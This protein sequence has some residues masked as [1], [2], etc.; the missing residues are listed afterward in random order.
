[1]GHE[2]RW[3]KEPL[4]DAA[5]PGWP[6]EQT[7]PRWRT[8]FPGGEDPVR[9]SPSSKTRAEPL[10]RS[11]VFSCSRAAG[12]A[13]MTSFCDLR[14]TGSYP[15]AESRGPGWPDA[16]I[17]PRVTRSGV[18]IRSREAELCEKC[19]VYKLT[20]LNDHCVLFFKSYKV[21]SFAKLRYILSLMLRLQEH[22][23]AILE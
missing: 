13:E 2:G 10:V 19:S 15:K 21:L 23:A 3:G 4:R 18:Y 9:M 16:G 7:Q 6:K 22:R 20:D 14:L 1:M 8:G 5:R 17:R 12:L 11:V